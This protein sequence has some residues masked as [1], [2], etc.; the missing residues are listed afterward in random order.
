VDALRTIIGPDTGGATAIQLCARAVLLFVFGV[1]CIR[2]AGRRTFSQYSPL[3]IIVAIVVGSNISRI[4]TGKASFF[5]G[6]AAT[7]ALVLLHRLV[8]MV[9]MRWTALGRL[10]KGRPAE[11]IRDGRI[12]EAALRRHLLTRDDLM[13]GLRLQKIADPAKVQVATLEGGGK[14]SVVER[15]D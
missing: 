2:I 5:T 10:I 8:A 3:D 12:D 4:M 11:L 15:K 7:F 1:V 13:E 6:L 14:I 9:S